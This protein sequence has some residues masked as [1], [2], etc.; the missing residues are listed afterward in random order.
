MQSQKIHHYSSYSDATAGQVPLDE[1]TTTKQVGLWIDH[2]KAVIVTLTDTDKGHQIRQIESHLESDTRPD[3]G[4]PAHSRNDDKTTA[5]DHQD[6]RFMG[7]L[8]RYYDEVITA[9][10]DARSILIFGPG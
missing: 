4:W 3:A 9:I 10:H 5:E 7:H 2:R 6:R 1:Q 8:D